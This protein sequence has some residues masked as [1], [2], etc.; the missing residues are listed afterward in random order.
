MTSLPPKESLTP[1]LYDSQGE[2]EQDPNIP[3]ENE[4]LGFSQS[5]SS[6]PR[7]HTI[8]KGLDDKNLK[9]WVGSWNIGCKTPFAKAVLSSDGYHNEERLVLQELQCWMDPNCDIYVVC[10]QEA[11]GESTYDA[12]D[13]Y[14]ALP[15]TKWKSP[16]KLDATT[17][18]VRLPMREASVFGYG[19][20]ALFTQKHTSIA[21]W[22]RASMLAPCGPVSLSQSAVASLGFTSGSK[23]AVAASLN[24]GAQEVCFVSCHLPATSKA[25]RVESYWQISCRLGELFT[26]GDLVSLGAI[27]HHVVWAGDFNFRVMDLDGDGVLGT[28]RNCSEDEIQ[29][30]RNTHDE[31]CVAQHSGTYFPLFREPRM[32]AGFLPTYKRVEDQ[33]PPPVDMTDGG[34]KETVEKDTVEKETVEKE[35]VDKETVEKETVEKETVEKETV[36][37]ETVEK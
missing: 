10:L 33:W 9:L 23:G 7:S 36:E 17:K 8:Y 1:N 27:F 11:I 24:I 15:T 19:D 18:Y 4:P 21:I 34:E 28:M 25:D 13:K 32:S 3:P 29:K 5:Q 2:L 12:I 14:L 35:T 37:K 30:M 16:E 26:G 20:G 22:V 6:S 31:Y